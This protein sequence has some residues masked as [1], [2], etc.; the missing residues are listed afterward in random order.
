MYN[1][2]TS[3]TKKLNLT[4]RK[5][6]IIILFIGIIFFAIIGYPLSQVFA[7]YWRLNQQFTLGYI[8]SINLFGTIIPLGEISIRFY[9]ICILL[10]MLAGYA[11]AIFLSKWNYVAGTVVDRLFIGLVIF[12]IVGARTFY[13]IFNWAAFETEP[14]NALLIFRGGLGFFGMI[15]ACL[16]YLWAYTSRFKFNTWEF[17]DFLAPSV[18]IGQIIGRFGNLF[19]YESYGPPTKVFWK[20]YI[21][22]TANIYSDLNQNFFHPTFLYEII[23]NFILLFVILYFYRELTLKR[24]GLVFATYAIGYGTIRLFTEIFRLDALIFNINQIAIPVSQVAAFVFLIYGLYT[25]YTRR[26]VIYIKKTMAEY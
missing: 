1:S 7:G 17:L 20:M 8:E 24:S 12:G 22:D 4:P 18:L 14:I 25:Y 16:I 13:V 23:P 9:S 11:M 5:L 10:G 2:V 26:K 19:N 6:S 15:I 3:K 21:P